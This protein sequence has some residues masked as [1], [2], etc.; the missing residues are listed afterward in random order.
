MIV[1]L[2]QVLKPDFLRTGTLTAVPIAPFSI[3]HTCL[4]TSSKAQACAISHC[5]RPFSQMF[6]LAEAKLFL[7][8]EVKKSKAR[9]W[10]LNICADPNSAVSFV[11]RCSPCA[12][13]C[14]SGS[15]AGVVSPCIPKA[16]VPRWVKADWWPQHV[17]CKYCIRRSSFFSWL[18]AALEASAPAGQIPVTPTASQRARP[19]RQG[20]TDV[21]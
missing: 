12:R 2:K 17:G 18:L 11:K 14:S 4:G 19:S 5:P 15:G 1:V 16:E 3:Y 8:H 21:W 9:G 20:N 6:A 13:R 10:S 7:K